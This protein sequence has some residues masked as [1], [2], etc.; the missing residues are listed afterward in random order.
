MIL[1][2]EWKRHRLNTQRNIRL[3]MEIKKNPH[4]HTQVSRL[5]I[6]HIV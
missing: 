6:Y 2:K 1:C 5:D 4:L 3:E